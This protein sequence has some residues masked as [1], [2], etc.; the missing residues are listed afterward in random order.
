MSPDA[1][2]AQNFALTIARWQREH[3]RQGLPWQGTRDPYFVWLSEIMLQQTQV[4][5]VIDYYTRFIA[6]FPDVQTLAAAA[7]DEVMPYWA[8]LGYYA[9]ARNLHR[10]AQK[11]CADWRGQ[12]PLDVHT[13]QTL[14]GI[15]R[16]TAAAIAAF[17]S[18]QRT[19]ILDGNVKRV[20]ARCFGVTEYPGLRQVEQRLWQ[21]AES[22]VEHAPPDLDMVA[23][24]QGLMDLGSGICT[25]SK[26]QCAACPLKQHCVA[27]SSQTQHLI[28]APKPRTAL[29]E[30]TCCVL[31]L[32]TAH[33]VLLQRRPPRGIWGGLW[34]L[35]Q[36]ETETA[37]RQFCQNLGLACNAEQRMAAFSHTFTHFKLH[38]TPWLLRCKPILNEPSPSDGEPISAWTAWEALAQTALPAPIKKL[39]SGVKPDG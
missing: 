38:I 25:R 37:L 14:P 32:H 17:C 3:G 20:F 11:I 35:P 18:G 10:C 31:I 22:L 23:Y 5:T 4:A 13:L 33:A 24:T 6:R 21:L 8:G 19:P 30:R 7:S 28:P 12:F 27:C 15:G 9:R 26:P 2:I 16:S 29:P 34:T 36:F 39:L 1:D